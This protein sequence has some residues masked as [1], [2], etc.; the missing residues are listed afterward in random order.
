MIKLELI[1]DEGKINVRFDVPNTEGEK[2]RLD[3]LAAFALHLD[4]VKNRITELTDKAIANAEGY[5]LI[6]D[7]EQ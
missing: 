5:E 1:A 4:V 2:L 6:V 7:E 3:E